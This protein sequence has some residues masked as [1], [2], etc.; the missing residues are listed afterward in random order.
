M[1]GIQSVKIMTL[2]NKVVTVNVIMEITCDC[3]DTLRVFEPHGYY[4]LEGL[5]AIINRQGLV[6]K[7]FTSA[8]KD[9]RRKKIR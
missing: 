5:K 2:E 8:H 1:L 7:E 4:N 3:G 9:C 6:V